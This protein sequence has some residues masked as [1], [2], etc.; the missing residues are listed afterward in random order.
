MDKGNEGDHIRS[1]RG[2]WSRSGVPHR[3]WVCVGVED[4]QAVDAM[5]EM[6]ES[7]EIRYVHHMVHRDFSGSLSVGCIC[8]GHMEGSVAAS[9]KREA[10]MKNR[11]GR[12]RRFPKL[13]WKTSRSGNPTRETD[14]FRVT[15]WPKGDLW[16]Y[17][18]ASKDSS[19]VRHSRRSYGSP[20]DAKLGSFDCLTALLASS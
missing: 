10:Q 13:R 19:V 18:V 3:G 5:C 2:K 14:G 6:C 15:I 4:L 20:D 8:A 16:C 17:T 7:T 11:A 1:G 12:R 9:Q